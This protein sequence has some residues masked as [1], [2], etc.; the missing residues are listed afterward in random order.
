M[1]ASKQPE[2]APQA[3]RGLKNHGNERREDDDDGKGDN[4]REFSPE[5]A[6]NLYTQRSDVVNLGLQHL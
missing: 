4:H 6:K 3:S 2:V 1:I 5:S